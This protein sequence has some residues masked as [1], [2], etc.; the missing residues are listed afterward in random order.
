MDAARQWV[1]LAYRLPR[2]PSTP[3]ITL[4]R[5]LKRL[6][7]V[8]VLDSLAGLPA[9]SRTREQ[10][11][12]LAQEVSEAGGEASVW[13]AAPLSVTEARD[14]TGRLTTSVADEY[15]ELA[16]AAAAAQAGPPGTRSRT[17]GRLRRE[18][19]RI[20]ERDYTAPPARD[21]ARTALDA[22]AAQLE[23]QA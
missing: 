5:K 20:T 12:W 3:R 4:W 16:A 9:T 7:A 13:L 2:E 15:R 22:L 23:V 11:E 6:G 17:L 1:L 8:Q 18:F 19:R 14:L 10:F 21:A